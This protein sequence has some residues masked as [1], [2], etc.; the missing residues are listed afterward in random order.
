MFAMKH[1]GTAWR[2][3]A[4]AIFAGL[5]LAGAAWAEPPPGNRLPFEIAGLT[6]TPQVFAPDLRYP[7][8]PDPDP[9]VRVEIF[10]RNSAPRGGTNRFSCN[11]LRF[12]NEAPL[13]YLQDN[14]WAWHDTPSLWSEEET[15]MLPG[16]LAVWRFNTKGAPWGPGRTFPITVVD[17]QRIAQSEWEVALNPQGVW[18]SSI[19]FTSHDGNVSPDA[20]TLHIA[21]QSAAAARFIG[22]RLFLPE[23]N[24]TYRALF[25]QP[26]LTGVARHPAD[27]WIAPGDKGC[28][29]ARVG[30]LPLTYAAVQAILA[31]ARGQQFAIWAHLR[32]KREVFDIGGGWV[33]ESDAPGN[34]PLLEP[35]LKT[36]QR[37]HVNTA[38]LVSI[39]GY[40]DQNGPSGLYTRYPL[41]RFGPLE[42]ASLFSQDAMLPFVHGVEM[43]GEPQFEEAAPRPPQAVWQSLLPFAKSRLITTVTLSDAST[44]R[45]YA[46]LS[47]FPHFDAYRVAAPSA[48]DW[49]AYDRWG[50]KRIAWG[51][52][53]ETIGSMCRS[54]REMSRPKPIAYWSQGPHFGWNEIGERKRTSPTP[55]EIRLQAY[56]ALSSR[57][58]SLYWFNLSLRSLVQFRD[59]IEE[60]TR[61]GR[62]INMLAD[63]Y[64]EGDAYRYRR[65]LRDGKPDWD[66]ASIASPK[67]AVLFA[68][69][70]DYEPDRG[71]K[72][73]L[74]KRRREGRFN[75]D[76]PVYLRAPADVFRVD[77][78]GV[79]DVKFE[80]H[81]TGI[82]IED[83]QH[84][85]AIYV[86]AP[87]RETRAAI[88]RKRLELVAAEQALNFD[89]AR[90]G[91]DF[92]VLKNGL[93]ER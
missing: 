10:V 49:M 42:P 20:V 71:D 78:E 62:E 52:P 48:D 24:D 66:L 45:Y 73:F 86:A 19:V 44:W 22:A 90:R 77:A 5:F 54:L 17:W 69:D 15:L 3:R 18:F 1:E 79:Y 39:P 31:D 89:P 38:N 91:R 64:I 92:D 93:G 41:K 13:K 81:A 40:T 57:I 51:A 32:I 70:L 43:L 83:R 33:Q 7:E 8:A 26:P 35:F 53:L 14:L 80:V 25:P 59:T 67:G 76:L 16:S 23:T 63:F 74:F 65:L 30:R 55:D 68:L 88:E 46:G 75:F 37:M 9:G 4:A 2:V 82:T 6:V 61:I 28:F 12:A 56:H 84:K 47:D 58:T 36:L 72:V 21:N 29:Q 11:A 50:E 34:A 60:I 87:S 85:V 27:G